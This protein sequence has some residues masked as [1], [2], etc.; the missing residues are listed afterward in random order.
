MNVATVTK[1]TVLTTTLAISKLNMDR[2]VC[3]CVLRVGVCV[4]VHVW[5]GVYRCMGV[6]I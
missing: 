4:G 1:D 2:C 3:M 6:G 5:V